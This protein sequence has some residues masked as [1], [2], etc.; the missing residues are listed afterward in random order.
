MYALHYISHALLKSHVEITDN[1]WKLQKDKEM[2]MVQIN[3]GYGY[4]NKT[5]TVQL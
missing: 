2:M 3:N 5:G 4:H 1:L